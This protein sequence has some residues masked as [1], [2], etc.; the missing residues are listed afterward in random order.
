M[1]KLLLVLITFSISLGV[2]A[3][4]YMRTHKN[5]GVYG[6]LNTSDFDKSGSYSFHAG[7]TR[8]MGRYILP[9]LG[10]R[11]MVQRDN[12]RSVELENPIRRGK[13]PNKNAATETFKDDDDDDAKSPLLCHVVNIISIFSFSNSS[14]DGIHSRPVFVPFIRRRFRRRLRILI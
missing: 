10:Y 1:K 9:E 8:Q 7:V 3:Q 5:F 4:V 13:L 12:G 6:Q 14:L 11:R 2:D